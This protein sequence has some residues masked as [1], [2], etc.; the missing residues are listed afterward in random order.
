MKKPSLKLDTT[1]PV[2]YLVNR[3]GNRTAYNI[4]HRHWYVVELQTLTCRH[5]K[6]QNFVVA[7]EERYAFP[8]LQGPDSSGKGKLADLIKNHFHP[9]EVETDC[10]SCG[11]RGKTRKTQ[12]VRL[13]PLLR[14]GIT[15][16]DQS[17][18]RKITDGLI[19][20]FDNLNLAP[21]ALEAS[22]RKEIAEKLGGEAS[23]GFDV[24]TR[25]DLYAVVVHNGT[26]LNS[27]HYVCYVRTEKN[28]W[29]RFDDQTITE[30]VKNPT[31]LANEFY[32][33]D[34]GYTPVQLYYQ[35]VDK[36]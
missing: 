20:P 31:T 5:C 8:V 12:I 6:A 10:D 1:K 25:Y 27:G 29:T 24:P 18:S 34:H 4:I 16:T 7:E 3:W 17:S 15:R 11:L 9:E 33:C 2:D 32:R 36:K 35:R 19:F 26:T 28:K 23:Q 13:P 30:D 14:V 22:Q 21:H